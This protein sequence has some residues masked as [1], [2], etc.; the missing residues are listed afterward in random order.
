MTAGPKRPQAES[1]FDELKQWS[2]IKLRILTKYLDTYLRFRLGSHR[3]IY[4]VDGFAG[5]SPIR[6][7]RGQWRGVT[8]SAG[9]T[10]S[11]RRRA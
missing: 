8:S 5:T 7:G 3:R 11:G 4:Y 2:E 9:A 1:F 10:G 6:E